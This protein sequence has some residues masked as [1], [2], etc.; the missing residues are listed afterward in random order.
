VIVV[1]DPIPQSASAVP[2]RRWGTLAR[3]GADLRWRLVRNRAK[4]QGKRSH[5][6]G[7]VFAS[8]YAGLSIIGLWGVRFDNDLAA[9]RT[10]TLQVSAIALAWIFGPILLGGVDE[11]V[12][13]TRLALLP[14]RT[15]ELF[16]VQV[17]AALSGLAPMS[18]AAVLTVGV[19]LGFSPLTP[20]FVLPPLAGLCALV[21]VLGLARTTAGALAR[22][23]RTRR[24]RDLGVLV[25][26]FAGG[27]LFVATQLAGQVNSDIAGEVVD[28][29]GWTPW[30]WCVRSAVAARDGRTIDAIGWLI[31]SMVMAAAAMWLWARLTVSMLQ[32]SERGTNRTAKKKGPALRGATTELGASLAR[33]WIYVQRSPS[34]R[35]GL[36]FGTVFGVAFPVLQILQNGV[37]DADGVVFGVLLAMLVNIGA[38]S[39]VI[40]FDAGSLWLE[41]QCGGP[42]RAQL[43]ARSV[44]GLPNLLLPTWISAVVVGVWTGRASQ[45]V[46][47]SLLAIPVSLVI[48]A[49]GI[50]TS[51]VAAFPIADGDNPFGNRQAMQGRGMRLVLSSLAGLAAVV[52]LSAPV[53]LAVYL[54]RNAWWGWMSVAGG[55]VWGM[56]LYA[57]ALRWVGRKVTGS[58]PELLATLAPRAL[59]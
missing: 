53:V 50:V 12:D 22:A 25:A 42:R 38:V 13:P 1:G 14:L 16:C 18:A 7:I 27:G 17:S 15:S 49:E 28:G 31:P 56:G 4:R 23:Q 6:L 30:G 33:Q 40:G 58:E 41:V 5:T 19:T 9:L 55:L 24:G 32:S 11:T 52:V 20:A 35:V 36:L 34:I 44:A 59:L 21:M 29:L 8:L 2:Q 51:Y 45:V 39:N 46:L 48:L 43:I 10:L 57:L 54:G 3:L 26:A 47:V 37:D